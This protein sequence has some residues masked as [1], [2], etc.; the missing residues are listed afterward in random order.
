MAADELAHVRACSTASTPARTVPDLLSLF[1]KKIPK[2]TNL[3]D[4]RRIPPE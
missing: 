2:S 3:T 1:E 4:T